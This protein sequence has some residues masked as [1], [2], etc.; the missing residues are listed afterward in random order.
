[1]KTTAYISVVGLIVGGI[2]IGGAL[3]YT[4]SLS[5]ASWESRREVVSLYLAGEL[6]SAVSGELKLSDRH[7]STACRGR[8]YVT[9][10]E[11]EHLILFP[12]WF[13]KGSNMDGYLF[14]PD[15]VLRTE[16]DVLVVRPG[17]SGIEEC[18]IP[19]VADLG[20]GWYQVYYALD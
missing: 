12:T 7:A 17:P 16:Q 2:L 4:R 13:G 18:P 6:V 10:R 9:K 20:G 19:V 15:T 14:S 1:M 5:R 11:Q 8:A 3:L